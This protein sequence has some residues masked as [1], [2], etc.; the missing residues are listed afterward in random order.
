MFGD[1]QVLNGKY[2]AYIKTS[3]G[4][5]KIPRSIDAQTLTQEQ[6]MEI[7]ASANTTAKPK[8]TFTKRYTKK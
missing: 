8:K 5:Y 1:I 2:G 4:N 3:E 6:C 7:I